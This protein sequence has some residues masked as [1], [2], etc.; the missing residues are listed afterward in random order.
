M[1]IRL[2]AAVSRSQ[3]S[4]AFAL[5][6]LTLLQLACASAATG[7]APATQATPTA[8]S[9][10]TASSAA[11]SPGAG[12]TLE[13]LPETEARYRVR[14]QLANLSFPSDAVGATKAVQGSITFSSDGRVVAEQS[15]ITVDLSQLRSDSNTR[16]NYIRRTSLQTSSY[17]G[18]EFVVKGIEGLSWPPPSTGQLDLRIIGD[19]TIRG[20]TKETTWEATANVDGNEITGLATTSF[21][22]A[23]FGMSKPS[24]LSVLSVEDNVRLEID[25]HLRS[26]QAGL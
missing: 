19:L 21:R 14:E 1:R 22:F 13:V 25:F 9:T 6:G 3:W 23:D 24:A 15:R 2:T 10:T 11:A 18:A 8:S 12:V 7:P 16:D 26:T 5:L 4:L 17:P 20:V